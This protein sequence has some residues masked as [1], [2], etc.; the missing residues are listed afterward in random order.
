MNQTGVIASLGKV[1]A[2]FGVKPDEP[3]GL[4]YRLA[5]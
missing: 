4:E 2:D 3:A 1:L 5:Q